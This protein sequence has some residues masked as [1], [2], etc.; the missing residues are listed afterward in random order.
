[1]SQVRMSCDT[2]SLGVMIP[3]KPEAA[4]CTERSIKN[5]RSNLRLSGSVK[6]PLNRVGWPTKHNTS[7]VTVEALCDNLLEKPDLYLAEMLLPL[8]DE[9]NTLPTKFTIS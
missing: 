5:I 3:L 7:D 6:T 8:W 9:L 4:G 2:A 1:M